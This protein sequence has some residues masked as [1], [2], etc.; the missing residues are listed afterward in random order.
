MLN[1]ASKD[2]ISRQLESL[3]IIVIYRVCGGTAA[4]RRRKVTDLAGEFYIFSAQ[5]EGIE[6]AIWLF[7]DH[8][9]QTTILW[10]KISSLTELGNTVGH[11][12]A[13][14]VPTKIARSSSLSP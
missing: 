6:S 13:Q 9:A 4:D 2:D 5:D 7:S 11:L 8:N 12:G 10:S 1:V 3:K 14:I